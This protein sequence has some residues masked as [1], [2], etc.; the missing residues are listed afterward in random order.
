MPYIRSARPDDSIEVVVERIVAAHVGIQNFWS[1]PK[2]WAPASVT[3][4]FERCRLDRQTQL[5][6]CLSLWIEPGSDL[7][8]DGRLIIARANL[9]ALV[10]GAMQLGLAVF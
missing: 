4:L 1:S 3:K 8:A 5:A 7:L 9:G 6:R 10:E 2:G